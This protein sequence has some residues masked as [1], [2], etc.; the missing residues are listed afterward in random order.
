MAKG[1]AEGAKKILAAVLLFSA[2]LSFFWQHILKNQAE[3]YRRTK[4]SLEEL[5]A[6]LGGLCGDAVNAAQ[7]EELFL[8]RT[9]RE[10]T[11]LERRLLT[12]G[13]PAAGVLQL[14]EK[15]ALVAGVEVASCTFQTPVKG[16]CYQK[17]PVQ[18]TVKGE[19]P[20]I[21]DFLARLEK[22]PEA[23]QLLSLK[24]EEETQKPG[25]AER[26]AAVAVPAGQPQSAAHGGLA[27]GVEALGGAV[28]SPR[29]AVALLELEF[30]APLE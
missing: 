24:V 16:G 4:Q 13:H 17:V 11:V 22:R 28:T 23:V 25:K 19:Y 12:D 20:A 7:R 26:P 9:Q 14:L 29:T 18:V 5:R 8:E 10:V 30:C 1:P 2:C 15:E 6:A 21:F 27:G 3:D